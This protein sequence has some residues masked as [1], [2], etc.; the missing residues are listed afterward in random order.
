MSAVVRQRLCL[1][2]CAVS[3]LRRIYLHPATK[4]SHRKEIGDWRN[5]RKN[6]PEGSWNS[7]FK[8]FV[9]FLEELIIPKIAFETY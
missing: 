9:H 7:F 1:N 4:N 2:P 5:M 3:V 8:P 6:N